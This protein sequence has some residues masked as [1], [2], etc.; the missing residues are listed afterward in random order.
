MLNIVRSGAA[1]LEN[2]LLKHFP[3]IIILLC[4]FKPLGGA[5]HDLRD[6]I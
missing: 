4:K 2:I 5:I 6:F 3:I 1:V